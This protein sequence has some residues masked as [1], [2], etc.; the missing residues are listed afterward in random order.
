MGE[1]RRHI[2]LTGLPGAGKSTVGRLVATALGAD[3]VDV[4]RSIEEATGASVAAVFQRQ[5]ESAFRRHER[6]AV[7]DLVASRAPC[8][9]ATGGG[10]AAGE[11]NLA[12]VAG[13]GLTVYLEVSAA[14]A[15][16]RVAPA[17]GRP[18]L[19]GPD[20]E[21]ALRE[22]Y[23]RRREYYER[24]DVTIRAEERSAEAVAA[25]VTELARRKG[26]W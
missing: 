10:W 6:D 9:V 21:G 25:D 5:G 7:A 16:A 18:L 22:L 4:D 14:T 11:G 15:W 1:S 12:A 17:A 24:A 20:P 13:V 8:V 2:F 23:A 19:A 26:G 3:F